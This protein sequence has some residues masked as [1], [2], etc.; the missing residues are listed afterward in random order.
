M[1]LQL[2]SWLLKNKAALLQAIEVARGWKPAAP[3]MEKWAVIDQIARL[4]VPIVEAEIAKQ[5]VFKPMSV[6]PTS[7]E[8]EVY[9]A[10]AMGCEYGTLAIDWQLVI[11]VILPILKAILETLRDKGVA[12]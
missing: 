9:E 3:L 12:T 6:E 5:G 8:L 7:P 2:L 11:S 1:N 4:L 10:F